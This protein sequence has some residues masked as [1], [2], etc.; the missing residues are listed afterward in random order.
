MWYLFLRQWLC[1]VKKYIY[2]HVYIV[3]FLLFVYICF[4]IG[5]P[6]IK[7]GGKRP[8]NW[9]NLGTYLCLSQARTWISNIVCHGLFC[10]QWVKMRGDCSFRWYWW[11]CWPSLSNLSV[12]NLFNTKRGGVHVSLTAH[13][14]VHI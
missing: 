4:A 2:I 6:V 13:W 12:H 1:F 7:R 9:F 3:D 10:V 8:I 11:N 14:G 5:D